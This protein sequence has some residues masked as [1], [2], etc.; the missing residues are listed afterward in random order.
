MTVGKWAPGEF[1]QFVEEQVVKAELLQAQAKVYG[2]PV[3][4]LQ[5]WALARDTG[6]SIEEARAL[7]AE[8]GGTS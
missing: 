4:E 3:E 1:R 2:V 6:S 8:F 7:L 5:A